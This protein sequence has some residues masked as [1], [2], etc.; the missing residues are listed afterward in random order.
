M[1][2]RVRSIRVG[3]VHKAGLVWVAL[4]HTGVKIEPDK[5][6]GKSKHGTGPES[7]HRWGDC[8]LCVHTSRA[9]W[10]KEGLQITSL[11]KYSPTSVIFFHFV[12][13]QTIHY[14]YITY[15]C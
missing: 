7:E 11:C 6:P 8:R 5:Q 12:N 13:M 9:E 3:E 2:G 4:R 14:F 10:E 1:I 15:G